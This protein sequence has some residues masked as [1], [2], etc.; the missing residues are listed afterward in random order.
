MKEFG[1]YNSKDAPMYLAQIGH[2]SQGLLYT[3]EIWGPTPTQ[4]RY[5]GRIDLGNTQPGDGF[6]C[7]GFGPIQVTGRYNLTKLGDSLGADFINDSATRKDPS[8]IARS[9]GWYWSTHNL[10]QWS[11]DLDGCSDMINRG[12]VTR[13]IGDS[14]GFEDRKKRYERCLLA[15]K[16]AVFEEAQIVQTPVKS[17]K[18]D[19]IQFIRKVIGLFKK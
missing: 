8:L 15:L 4:S 7:R 2:E 9:A 10:S 17:E 12:R 19:W 16:D 18:F 3:E 5:E 13:S 6:A 11:D 14:N 1:T